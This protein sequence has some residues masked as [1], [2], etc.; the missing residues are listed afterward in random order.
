MKNDFIISRSNID[1]NVIITTPVKP[2]SKKLTDFFLRID[3]WCLK[4]G[5]GYKVV[6]FYTTPKKAT[7]L[8]F[9]TNIP[10]SLYED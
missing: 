3:A 10:Y 8:D 2:T 6:E 9:K 1:G 5:E 4:F 7:C